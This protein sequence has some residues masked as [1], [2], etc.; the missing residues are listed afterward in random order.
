MAADNVVLR[1]VGGGFL[2]GVDTTLSSVG[3]YTDVV[4]VRPRSNLAR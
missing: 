3:F 4:C 1:I 2:S